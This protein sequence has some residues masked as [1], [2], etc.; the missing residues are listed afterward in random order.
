M[1]SSPNTT[2]SR[3]HR[4]RELAGIAL[5]CAAAGLVI[6]AF[7]G[8]AMGMSAA[9][10]DDWGVSRVQAASLWAVGATGVGAIVGMLVGVLLYY[11]FFK[12][13]L[14]SV[15]FFQI[16]IVSLIG[17]AAVCLLTG[18]FLLETCWLATPIVT[19]LASAVLKTRRME[20]RL[21]EGS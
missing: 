7:D 3:L 19:I 2:N 11:F 5:A 4:L 9:L 17:G 8:A 16:A 14:S 21:K 1:A 10:H 12:R 15:E 6:G 13:Q 20:R 18:R